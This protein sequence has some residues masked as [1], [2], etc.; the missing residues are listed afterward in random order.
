M[1]NNNNGMLIDDANGKSAWKAVKLCGLEN[2]IKLGYL[3]FC[4]DAYTFRLHLLQPIHLAP[5]LNFFHIL[6]DNVYP[7][8]YNSRPGSPD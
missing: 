6:V 4:L 2:Y 1:S 8:I 5:H 3:L 7:T